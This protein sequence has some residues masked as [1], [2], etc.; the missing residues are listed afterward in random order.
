[1]V[2]EDYDDL[3]FVIAYQ[4]GHDSEAFRDSH[5]ANPYPHG[6][7]L[8]KVWE[9]GADD[10][11]SGFNKTSEAIMEFVAKNYDSNEKTNEEVPSYQEGYYWV[12]RTV[13]P[14]II[15]GR[16]KWI[17]Y[18]DGMMWFSVGSEEAFSSSEP[19]LFKVLRKVTETF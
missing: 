3:S 6:S 1:M 13:E 8:W 5:L 11:A 19:P 12:E 7:I 15:G 18:F 17:M 16:S 2:H 14:K 4:D 10:A 9:L